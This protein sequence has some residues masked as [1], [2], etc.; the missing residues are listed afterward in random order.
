MSYWF[1]RCEQ[2]K[3]VKFE[4]ADTSQVT[5]MCGMFWDC[6]LLEKLNLN[7]FDLTTAGTNVD[8]IL[9]GCLALDRIKSPSKMASGT[10]I[11]FPEDTK[12]YT[13][14]DSNPTGIDKTNAIYYR[15]NN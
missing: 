12:W 15:N 8:Y 7:S 6:V 1:A 11:E 10:V 13:E 5:D 9:N 14:T 2:L 3:E 4:N